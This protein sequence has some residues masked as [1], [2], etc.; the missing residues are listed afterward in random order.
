MANAPRMQWVSTFDVAAR[1]LLLAGLLAICLGGLQGANAQSAASDTSRQVHPNAV[2]YESDRSV[3]YHVLA[4]PAYVLHGVTRP[5]GWTVKY[6]E[7]NYPGLFKPRPRRRG[8]LPLAE[9]GGPVG[10]TG[11]VALYDRHL[12]GSRHRGR[13]EAVIGARDF[14]E[15]EARYE[16]P[17]VVGPGTGVSIGGNFFSEPEARFF[18]DGIDSDE[19]ADKTRFSRDQLDVTTRLQVQG[20]TWDVATELRYEHV[21]AGLAEDE[22]SMALRIAPGL[23]TVDLL[24]PRAELALDFTRGGPRTTA[25]TR[26]LLRADYTHDLNGSRFRYG[27][28]I[29]SIHQYVPLAF[30]PPGR[31]L[32]FRA[33]VEQVEPM[34]G[35]EAVPFYQLPRL[36]G[37]TSLRGFLS[38]RFQDNG[39]LLFTAEYRYPIWT[40]RYPGFAGVDAVFFVDTGQVFDAL[41]E[42]AAHDFKVS[43]GGG[44]HL[45]NRRGLSARFEV[46]RSVESTQV[47]LTVR[48]SLDRLP[49]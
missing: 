25:G 33:R 7:R 43:V 40:N 2:P 48:P 37:Q 46:A 12:F 27:R 13:I 18:V 10:I 22:T 44:L 6:L 17:D 39:S 11:G 49:R 30:F 5:V 23:T 41:D 14:F 35:G 4:A 3:L 38:N 34:L 29:A 15:V 1:R 42:V 28:Y 20:R 16:V 32:A 21:E 36:G 8:L 31:R 45:L 47:I 26:F 9:L 24:T 19:D